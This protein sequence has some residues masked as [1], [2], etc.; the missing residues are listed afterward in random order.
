MILPSRSN[1][2]YKITARNLPPRIR[3]P[4]GIDNERGGKSPSPRGR[5]AAAVE[6]TPGGGGTRHG[7]CTLF[8]ELGLSSHRAWRG[9]KP[10]MS[11]VFRG[12][13]IERRL[14]T[15]LKSMLCLSIVEI[16][17]NF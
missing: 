9:C 1:V 14:G 15:I 4:F 16:I 7:P 5:D 17:T 11:D 6:K 10:T 13:G 12:L 8:L 3:E 2:T